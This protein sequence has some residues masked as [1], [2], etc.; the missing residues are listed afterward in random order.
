VALEREDQRDVDRDAG[1][2]R[3]L[4]RG[5]PLLGR[6]DL[7][8]QVRPVDELAEPLRLVDRA[9]CVVRQVRVDLERD[10]AVAG[11]LARLVPRRPEDVA[12][13]LDV[14][15][16]QRQE[17]LLRLRLTPQDLAQLLV[18]GVALG[19]RALEDR[20]VRGDA[21]D[22][23]AHEPLQVAVLDE[24][25]REE[26]DPDA[27]TVGGEL[28]QRRVGHGSSYEGSR[29]VSRA[30]GE[31]AKQGL[32]G[33]ATRARERKTAPCQGVRP[34]SSRSHAATACSSRR[35][36]RR[37]AARAWLAEIEFGCAADVRGVTCCAGGR[38]PKRPGRDTS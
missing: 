1:G 12:G 8:E 30:M 19:D 31:D 11:V 6:R 2:D 13:G 18:V 28:L 32:P 14:L 16:G 38:A 20:R 4:D 22:A 7:D 33:A 26:V 23:V 34:A 27:L 24:G 9:L 17:D 36:A 29:V 10:P 37:R 35:A 5:Q 25:S 21:D 15:D 3:L